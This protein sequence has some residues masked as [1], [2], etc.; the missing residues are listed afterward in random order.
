MS[1][2]QTTVASHSRATRLSPSLP[3]QRAGSTAPSSTNVFCSARALE[4]TA[5]GFTWR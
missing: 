5:G 2:K 1:A 3:R 4:Y